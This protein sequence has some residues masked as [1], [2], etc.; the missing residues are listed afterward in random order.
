[1]ADLRGKV[2]LVTGAARGQGR[3]HCL[4]LARDGATVVALDVCAPVLDGVGYEPAT[5]DDLAETGRLVEAAGGTAMTKQA[6]VRSQADLDAAVAE[7]I[8]RYGPIGIVV[9]NAGVVSYARSWE[10]SDEHWQSVLDVNLTGVWR[11]AKAVIPSMIE[12]GQG[13]AMV[14]ISSTAGLRAFPMLAHYAAS[15]HGLVGLMRAMAQEL[16]PYGIRVNSVHPG[17]VDTVMGRDPDVPERVVPDPDY[18]LYYRAGKPLPAGIMHA[19]EIAAAVAWL[20]SDDARFVTGVT[21][22]VDAGSSVR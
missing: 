22:P 8:D 14:F 4:R 11:T 9:A 16:G 18:G 5:L 15:K 6:D 20:V 7:A 19:D 17:A 10:L 3:A 21:L 1:M 2:A 12:A 13:G